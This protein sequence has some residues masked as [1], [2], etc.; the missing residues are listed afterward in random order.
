MRGILDALGHIDLTSGPGWFTVCM[1]TTAEGTHT[2]QRLCPAAPGLHAEP[3]SPCAVRWALPTTTVGLRPPR[4][5]DPA[6]CSA[7]PRWPP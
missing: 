7:L 4:A 6:H 3:R 5:L 1:P 2:P